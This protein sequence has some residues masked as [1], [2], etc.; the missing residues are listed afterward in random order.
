M[1]IGKRKSKIEHRKSKIEKSTS[2]IEER[3]FFFNVEGKISDVLSGKVK[4]D[5]NKKRKSAEHAKK[6]RHEYI[7]YTLATKKR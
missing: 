2:K 5:D 4:S 7:S 3:F 1:D 6:R